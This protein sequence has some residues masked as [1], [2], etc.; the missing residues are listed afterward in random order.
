[1]GFRSWVKGAA[2]VAVLAV[3]AA[4]A[5]AQQRGGAAKSGGTEPTALAFKRAQDLTNEE[6]IV[7]AEQTTTR[8]ANTA[9]V[10]GRQLST[11]REQRD[12][13]KTLC[14]NDKKN[15]V[16]TTDRAARE[17]KDSMVAAIKAK[18]PQQ[19]NHDL[20]V[21]QVLGRRADGLGTSANQCVGEESSTLSQTSTTMTITDKGGPGDDVTDVQQNP[22]IGV[23]PPPQTASPFK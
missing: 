8:I 16:D 1:M 18:D 11:A 22:P 23:V 12:P 19:A 3:V 17:R 4:P 6:K 14:L 20:N 21:I 9:T 7:V 15:Q 10:I 5:V 13:V 2:V